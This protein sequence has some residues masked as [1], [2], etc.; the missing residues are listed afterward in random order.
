MD[1]VP[2]DN[3][4]QKGKQLHLCSFL[5]VIFWVSNKE[6]SLYRFSRKKSPGWSTAH[7]ENLQADI[8]K[9]CQA[10]IDKKQSE[11][12]ALQQEVKTLKAGSISMY[13][14]RVEY[15]HMSRS[16]TVVRSYMRLY[17]CVYIYTWCCNVICNIVYL[18]MYM[19]L[20][21]NLFT[22]DMPTYTGI[23]PGFW[24]SGQRSVYK[25]CISIAML[26][27]ASLLTPSGDRWWLA[28]KDDY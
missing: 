16:H 28:C 9:P 11:I 25:W 8:S 23:F 19:I 27:H 12:S 17:M 13:I 15:A 14:P 22:L 10:D 26:S 7:P 20:K 4:T 2:F 21:V 6:L 5:K 24:D 18:Y 3:L 1:M